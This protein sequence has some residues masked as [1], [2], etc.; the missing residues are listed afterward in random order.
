[1]QKR[2]IFNHIFS[3]H[4][5]EHFPPL[6]NEKKKKT[7]IYKKFVWTHFT[8]INLNSEDQNHD[9][10]KN[11]RKFWHK[12]GC[13]VWLHSAHIFCTQFFPL[14]QVNW[15]HTWSQPRGKVWRRSTCT[16]QTTGYRRMSCSSCRTYGDEW[17]PSEPSLSQ[18]HLVL[19]RTPI[20]INNKY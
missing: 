19:G 1:M 11:N 18:E 6:G 16:Q 9:C 12:N 14:L 7:S 10:F 8:W 20:K 4:S 17:S 3:T 15:S 2:I 13:N 5:T